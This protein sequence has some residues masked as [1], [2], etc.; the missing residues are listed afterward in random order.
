M[1]IIFGRDYCPYCQNSKKILNIKGIK[2]TYCSLEEKKN[3]K[4]VNILRELKLIPNN[5][6]TIPIVINYINR[7]PIFIGGYDKLVNFYMN[8]I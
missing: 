7:K 1:L 4:L 5:H 2:Y 3:D 6:N 8:K